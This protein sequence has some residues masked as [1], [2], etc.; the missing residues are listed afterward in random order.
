MADERF[1]RLIPVVG[2]DNFEKL[3]SKRVAVFGLGGVGGMTAEALARSGI[4]KLT[5]I[6]GDVFEES[7]VNRQIGALTSTFGCPKAEVMKKRVLEIN[8]GC[9]VEAMNLFYDGNVGLEAFD[10]IADCIDSVP[11][12]TKLI[13]AA[14]R[15]G[16]PVISVMGAGNKRDASRF[17]IA[18]IYSTKVCQLARVMRSRLK[19]EGVEKLN[20][21][22]SDEEPSESGV[23]GSFMPATAAA[24]L[25]AAQK[26]LSDLL[27]EAD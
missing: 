5:L 17:R 12:K 18:D 13:V 3:G 20:T 24:G 23:L 6:D 9:E 22:Y 2:K 7:N 10:Y 21:V 27:E 25:L 15:A 8:P 1:S 19:K 14:C 11:Q 16:I 4:G 26:I